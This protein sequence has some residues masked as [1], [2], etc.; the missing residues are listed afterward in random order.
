MRVT[1]FQPFRMATVLRGIALV[2]IAGRLVTL[3]RSEGWLGRVRAIVIAA[4]LTGDWLFVVVTLAETAAAAV[5]AISTRLRQ[6]EQ[7]SFVDA[8]VFIAVL[9]PGL[10]FLGHHDTEYGNRT[11]VAALGVGVLIGVLGRNDIILNVKSRGERTVFFPP[12]QRGGQGGVVPAQ[13][14]ARRLKALSHL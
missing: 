14:I 12:L 9:A 6:G 1:V 10:S 13:S 4:A 7:R 2:F 3:W 11:L 5:E 8:A